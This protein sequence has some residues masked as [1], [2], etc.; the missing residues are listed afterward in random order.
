MIGVRDTYIE[1]QRRVSLKNELN[2]EVGGW[3][4]FEPAW[5]SKR[6]KSAA[7]SVAAGALASKETYELVT[8]YIPGL[9]SD[10][11]IEIDGQHF[12]ILGH[13]SPFRSKTV[14]QVERTSYER[15]N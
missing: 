14:I 7:E 10:M 11:R 8:D 5:A 1:I 3:E 12:A 4:V 6:L 2:E 15:R 9:S 13:D